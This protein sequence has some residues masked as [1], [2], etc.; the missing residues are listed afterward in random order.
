MCIAPFY[1]FI[2][3]LLLLGEILGYY[4]RGEFDGVFQPQYAYNCN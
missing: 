2:L 1:T 3:I 4:K